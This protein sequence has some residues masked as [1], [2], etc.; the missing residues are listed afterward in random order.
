ADGSFPIA[1]VGVTGALAE[2]L[3]DL[4][5]TSLDGVC[6]AQCPADVVRP[7]VGGKPIVAVIGHAD[8]VRFVA[9]RYGDEH[10][11]KY[12]LAC[13]APVVRHVREDGWDCI[14]ALAERTLLGRET[15][16]HHA[17][18]MPLEPFLDVA[19]HFVE[20]LLIDDG[21]NVAC[22]V[23]RI[24]E[25]ERFDLVPE[26]IKKIV[27]D[28]PVEEKARAGGAGLALPRKAHRGNDAVDD[29]ILICIG[30]N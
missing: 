7:D 21:A 25:L 15:P 24:T 17:R 18:F 19:T 28:V 29:P 4:N 9:P 10:W 22:L 3:V 23:E 26:R 1:T 12:L 8:R 16:D 20:L 5:P 14:I 2:T 11:T 6:R 30:E 13:Q 27:E